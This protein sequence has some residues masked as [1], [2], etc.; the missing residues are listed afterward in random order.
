M[1]HRTP[2]QPLV[3]RRLRPAFVLG[4][5]LALPV[6]SARADAPAGRYT[7]ANGTVTDNAT[8][9]VWQQTAAPA[10][11]TFSGAKSYCAGLALD[12]GGW[13]MPTV[14]ELMTLVDFSV[15]APG[16]TIDTTAFPAAPA[17]Y[18]W[19][20]ST[21]AANPSFGWSVY[22]YHGYTYYKSVATTYRVRCVR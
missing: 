14:K 4:V 3:L 19:T 15:A 8:K 20:S 13:R 7:I 17:D 21:L 11:Q 6:S 5:A 16:P 18:F 10:T 9:L 2:H 1:H 12:G 22:F